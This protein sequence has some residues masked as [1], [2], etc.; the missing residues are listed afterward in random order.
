MIAELK[1][2]VK[3][4]QKVK[5]F[6]DFKKKNPKAYLASCVVI[7]DGKKVGDWQIDFYQPSKH[8]M[9]TFIVKD[10][11]EFKGEDNI[12]QK[13]KAEVK[14]LKLDDVKVGFDKMLK[15]LEDFRKKNYSG[16][17]P[18]KTIIVLQTIEDYPVWNLT[19]LTATLKVLNVKL[20]AVDGKV[21]SDHIEN[22]LSFKAS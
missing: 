18:N 14:E 4:V 9:A 2:A 20:S 7:V 10:V 6:K 22:F 1:K 12:F 13:E 5:E 19:L 3:D 11:V 15:L 17:F 8:K 16:D 21:I